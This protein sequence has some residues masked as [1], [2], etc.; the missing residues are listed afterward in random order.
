MIF[1]RRDKRSWLRFVTESLWPRGGWGRAAQYVKHRLRRLPDHPHRIARGIF[2]GILASFTPLYGFHFL[3]AALFATVVRGNILASLL[4]T[5]AGNPL[6]FPF[7]AAISLKCGH[8]ILGSRFVEDSDSTLVE[9][10]GSAFSEVWQNL[11]AIF[12]PERAHWEGLRVFFD[13]VFLPYL[14]GG[15]VPGIIAGLIAYYVSLPLIAAYQNRRKLKLKTKFEA[16]R[17]A[18]AAAAKQKATGPQS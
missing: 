14:V 7:I 12:T 3:T 5:F 8:W 6:T 18:A 10:F 1:R 11:R 17:S 2:A 16:L 4:A 9:K 15:I 13:E